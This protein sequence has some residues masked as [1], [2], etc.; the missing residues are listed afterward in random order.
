MGRSHCAFARSVKQKKRIRIMK[1]AEL[2]KAAC[3]SNF[4]KLKEIISEHPTFEVENNYGSKTSL[5][6]ILI[7]DFNGNELN[8][9][10][11]INTI[12]WLLLQGAAPVEVSTANNVENIL[13]SIAQSRKNT[14]ILHL[15]YE[16]GA[17]IGWLATE[18][19][20]HCPVVLDDV[21]VFHHRFYE[22]HSKNIVDVQHTEPG[23]ENAIISAYEW[24]VQCLTIFHFLR[25]LQKNN[26]NLTDTTFDAKIIRQLKNAIALCIS[27]PQFDSAEKQML[28][29]SYL[30]LEAF[31]NH[32][33]TTL[34]LT[35]LFISEDF[36]NKFLTAY[37]QFFQQKAFPKNSQPLPS[38][39]II[40]DATQWS[41]SQLKSA[42]KIF[43]DD[44]TNLKMRFERYPYSN[45]KIKHEATLFAVIGI[46]T[47][48][49]A[50]MTSIFSN[51]KKTGAFYGTLSFAFFGLA[52]HVQNNHKQASLIPAQLRPVVKKTLEDI[53][54][55]IKQLNIL[56]KQSS[57]YTQLL[58]N[59]EQ[60]LEGLNTPKNIEA[61]NNQL[62]LLQES[63]TALLQEVTKWDNLQG[64]QYLPVKLP[65][66]YSIFHHAPHLEI[67]DN[68]L[69]AVKIE[70]NDHVEMD[71]KKQRS[72]PYNYQPLT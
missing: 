37:L 38:T 43:A 31:L 67:Q 9:S 63:L 61:A 18:D 68:P 42:L 1:D 46:Y 11:R 7:Q 32:P 30:K 14:E 5:L 23:F 51:N 69:T 44:I 4:D 49:L 15:L 24:S 22:D 6:R 60:L 58:A 21:V 71:E 2:N 8:K 29:D 70:G 65:L 47:I 62:F 66:Q 41:K 17:G 27:L 52:F 34:D 25:S 16:F 10:E 54:V 59:I 64:Q 13:L 36:E 19:I 28:R 20:A 57:T 3:D 35:N 40:Q 48:S 12:K 26:N 33:D 56:E 45:Q 72:N 55:W 50:V 53:S 39:Q